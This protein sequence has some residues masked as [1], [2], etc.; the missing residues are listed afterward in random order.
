MNRPLSALLAA[1]AAAA[2][3]RAPAQTPVVSATLKVQASPAQLDFVRGEPIRIDGK[4]A[5][6]GNAPLIVDDY[7]PYLDNPVKVYV[8]EASGGRLLDPRRGA[9][10]SA[11]ERLTVRPGETKDFSLDLRETYDLSRTGRYH[12]EVF[13]YRG[14]GEV[15]VS[16]KIS[17][18]I[19]EGVE[20]GSSVRALARDQRRP[21]RFALLCMDRNKR[22]ELFLRVTDAAEPARV[23]AFVSL[24]SLVRIA[25]PSMGFGPDDTVTVVQQVARDRYAR[26][27]ID[28]SG[29]VPVIAERD[30]NLLSMESVQADINTRLL[31]S[32]IA[33]AEAAKKPKEERRGVF[34]RQTTRTEAKPEQKNYTGTLIGQPSAPAK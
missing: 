20:I 8:R 30:D 12:A 22:Q 6:E 13:V 21:L 17:F 26:T 19:V 5:N 27:R 4:I 28:F 34:G 24:G 2:A 16:R 15:A 31:M 33:E 25:E 1:L 7:G 32:R 9:P 29:D 10:A 14:P 11:V 3:L 23:V 18:S